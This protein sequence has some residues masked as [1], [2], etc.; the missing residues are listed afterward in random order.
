MLTEPQKFFILG[1]TLP[2][3]S[4][5]YIE[6]QADK[7]L[8][9]NLTARNYCFVLNSR[10]MGKSSLCVRSI[11][12]LEEQG[13]R[14]AFVDLTQLG[15]RNSQLN[16]WYMALTVTIGR[17]LDLYDE[18]VAEF[19]ARQ[20]VSPM[21]RFFE[22]LRNVVLEQIKEPVVIFIDEIDAT[23]SLPFDTDEFFAG[24]RECYNRRVH[25]PAF[26]RLTFCLLGVAVPNDLIRN[27]STT[28][29]NIGTRIQVE[30]FAIE[31]LRNLA[32]ALGPNGEQLANR[33]HY[34]TNG[35]P[36]LTQTLCQAILD[37]KVNDEEGVDTIVGRLFF[38]PRAV[39]ANS[40]LSDVA[41]RVLNDPGEDGHPEKFRSNILST[42]EKVLHGRT[43]RG[44]RIKD[45]E[46]DRASVILKLSGLLRSERGCLVVRN[47]IYTKVFD[48]AWI[49]V[50]MPG[51]EVIRQKQSFRRGVVRGVALTA[52]ATA[53]IVGL[54]YYAWEERS[55]AI[56]A[57]AKLDHD[58]YVSDM[59][60]MRLF[61]EI[62]NGD[63][64]C[65]IP[66]RN[67]RLITPHR[68]NW[69]RLSSPWT[70]AKSASKIGWRIRPF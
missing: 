31:E 32:H 26:H 59:T 68:G 3:D 9:E 54:A 28:P 20:D 52:A 51:Q 46:S 22:T 34:W 10:Q 6:R 8:L 60:N 40:N 35:Q 29:F 62:G 21:T 18:A 1:G 30:D 17:A 44:S 37:N 57:Q 65:T 63:R 2:A 16:Q 39:D 69:N 48:R 47:R 12:K 38:G 11:S 45:L 61:Y 42:Y 36:F 64:G 14:T 50:N 25:D 7:D 15:G 58:L 5:S 70:A 66:L 33:V 53:L 43:G 55:Q 13:V 67:T 24:I 41:N 19:R 27:P 56:G 23:R 49:H 4:A